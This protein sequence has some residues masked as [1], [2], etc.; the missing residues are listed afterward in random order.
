MICFMDT[1]SI[2]LTVMD[3]APTTMADMASKLRI[4]PKQSHDLTNIRTYLVHSHGTF[5][6]AITVQRRRD[7]NNTESGT[8]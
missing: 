2:L 1:M 8:A 4:T 7:E 5:M 6:P 3:R